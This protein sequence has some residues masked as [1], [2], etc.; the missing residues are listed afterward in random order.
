M[1]LTTQRKPDKERKPYRH[2]HLFDGESNLVAYLGQGV[3]AALIRPRV[4]RLTFIFVCLFVFMFVCFNVCFLFLCLFVFCF[5]VCLFFVFMFVCLSLTSV[6][7]ITSVQSSARIRGLK[8]DFRVKIFLFLSRHNT[9][10]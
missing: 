5:Y 8:P 2:C 9:W 10:Q 1:A 6:A 4:P 7:L 3:H